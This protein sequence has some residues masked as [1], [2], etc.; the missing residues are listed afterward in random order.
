M[1]NRTRAQ[2]FMFLPFVRNAEKNC[3]AQA[4]FSFP[5]SQWQARNAMESEK[6]RYNN[7]LFITR[8]KA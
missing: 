5:L 6:K 4:S 8:I 7:N 1:Y 2:I 3:Q